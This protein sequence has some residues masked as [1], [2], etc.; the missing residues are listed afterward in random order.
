MA[1]TTFISM[2]VQSDDPEQVTRAIEAMS[3]C[4]AGLALEGVLVSVTA[5]KV[6]EED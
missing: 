3:R 2:S 6:D 4:A 1:H 5:G